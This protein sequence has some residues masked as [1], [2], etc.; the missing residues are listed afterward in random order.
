MEKKDYTGSCYIAVAGPDN[1]NGECR[2]SIDNLILRPGDEGPNFGRGTKGYATRQEHLNYWINKTVH[3][4]CLFLD[5]DQVFQRDALERLRVHKLPYISGFY[6]RRSWTPVAPVWFKPWDGRW[7]FLPWLDP[8]EKDTLYKIG[9]S[10]WGCVLLHR[11]VVMAVREMLHGEWEIL[12]DDMDI[13]PYDLGSIMAAMTGLRT[14]ITESPARSTLMPALEAHTAT[15]EAQIRPLRVDRDVIGSD[16]RFPWFALQAGYQLMGDSGVLCGH[17]INY[18]LGLNDYNLMPEE[19]LTHIRT[20]H[21]K[22]RKVENAQ[23][24]A[25]KAAVNAK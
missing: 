15:L 22:K 6:T 11:D 21:I 4:F 10:G 9:A 17:V 7:P 16:I 5:S 14:L 8:I 1:E 12:E 3:P 25:Q 24:E 18:P 2:D 23:I 13:W 20:E 19:M